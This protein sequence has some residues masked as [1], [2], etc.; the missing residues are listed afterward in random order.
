MF[1]FITRLN[2]QS[3]SIIQ[4]LHI[5]TGYGTSVIIQKYPQLYWK[6]SCDF[7]NGELRITDLEPI[8]RRPP[9]SEVQL[10]YLLPP[11]GTLLVNDSYYVATDAINTYLSVLICTKSYLPWKDSLDILDI[12]Y[13]VTAG[14]T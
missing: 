3:A 14:E 9:S 10:K 4:N 5:P 1:D 13:T 2:T 7:T 11:N 6:F 8:P 12:P